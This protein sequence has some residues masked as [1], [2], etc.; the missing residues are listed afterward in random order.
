MANE[1]KAKFSGTPPASTAM[2]ISLGSLASSTAGVGRQTTIVDNTTARYQAVEVFVKITQGTSPTGNKF[3][4]VYGIRSD[5]TLRS[6]GAGASDAGLTVLSAELI[7][8]MPNKSSP[9]TGDVLIGSFIFENPGPE[10]GIAIVHD[11]V[12][13]LNSTGGNHSVS[14]IG[15]N[16]EVQ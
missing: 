1:I 13:A 2:T 5:G 7:G 16:P 15:I 11:T 9:S 12:A 10:W 4:Y 14:Y 6:D 8:V 3:V